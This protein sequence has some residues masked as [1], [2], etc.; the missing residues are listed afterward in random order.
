MGKVLFRTAYL[1]LEA[2][3]H[4]LSSCNQLPLH[5]SADRNQNV[6][7]IMWYKNCANLTKYVGVT[8]FCTKKNIKY[9][10]NKNQKKMK[11]KNNKKKMRFDLVL[12]HDLRL[13]KVVCVETNI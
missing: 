9:K 11:I 2:L 10:Y 5:F 8:T 13:Q 7:T 1:R 6:L 3:W 4:S 12:I